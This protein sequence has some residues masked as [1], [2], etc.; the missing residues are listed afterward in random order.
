MDPAAWKAEPSH[1]GCTGSPLARRAVGGYSP[2][3]LPEGCRLVNGPCSLEGR[4]KPQRMHG[5]P[6]CAACC[7][8]LL[9]LHPAR[10][11][12]TCEWTLPRG[13]QRQRDTKKAVSPNR[14][15]FATSR[16]KLWGRSWP[17]SIIDLRWRREVSHRADFCYRLH[18]RRDD[19]RKYEDE[20]LQD[21][22]HSW[23]LP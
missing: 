9:T 18:C 10:R 2:S 16:P 17:E 22:R 20:K 23:R 3:T 11:V 6:A 15:V 4:T 5:V 12:P 13:Q 19:K 1:N 7:R 14:C 8:G 21:R